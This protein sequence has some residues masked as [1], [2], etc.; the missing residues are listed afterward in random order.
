MTTIGPPGR[1]HSSGEK[2]WKRS[3]PQHAQ[4]SRQ[5]DRRNGSDPPG[6]LAAIRWL[7]RFGEPRWRLRR[8]GRNSA[9]GLCAAILTACGLH[10]RASRFA[11]DSPLQQFVADSP[12]ERRGFE[13]PVSFARRV[14]FFRREEA[15]LEVDWDYPEKTYC[16]AGPMVRIRLRSSEESANHRFLSGG[17][18]HHAV[19][20]SSPIWSQ[21]F[22]YFLQEEFLPYQRN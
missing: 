2:L 21:E 18:H 9:T 4:K 1:F 6:P 15:V 8:Q 5:R 11:R 20:P 14:A 19:S 17:A 13:P 7:R 3:R 16:F 12:L 22:R 10:P